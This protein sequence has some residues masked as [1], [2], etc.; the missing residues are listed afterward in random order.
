MI[1]LKESLAHCSETITLIKTHS[2]SYNIKVIGN[3][4]SFWNCTFE[5]L[6]ERSNYTVYFVDVNFHNCL[7]KTTNVTVIFNN[8]TIKNSKVIDSVGVDIRRHIHIRIYHSYIECNESHQGMLLYGNSVVKFVVIS[9]TVRSC[10]LY[11]ENQEIVFSLSNSLLY[12]TFLVIHVL[13]YFKI[14]SVISMV[15][16]TFKNVKDFYCKSSV[17]VRLN[18]AYVTINGCTF[19]A[20]PVSL[21]ISDKSV[22]QTIFIVNISSSEFLN[23][24][25]C[26]D[27]GALWISSPVK[28]SIVTIF[29]CQFKDNKARKAKLFQDPHGGALA[30]ISSDMKVIVANSFFSNNY[31]PGAGNALFV[32]RGINISIQNTSF[33]YEITK[34]TDHLVPLAVVFGNA[35]I[36]NARFYINNSYPEKFMTDL[37]VFELSSVR[38]IDALIICPRWTRYSTDYDKQFPGQTYLT[39][40]V[41]KCLPCFESFYIASSG[42]DRVIY[43]PEEDLISKDDMV[44]SE[45]ITGAR[46]ENKKMWLI[47]KLLKPSTDLNIPMHTNKLQSCEK[48]SFGAY[49]SGNTIYP[50]PNYWGYWHKDKLIFLQ[51][52]PGYCCTGTKKAPCIK[53]NSCAKNKTGILCGQCQKNFSVAILSGRCMPNHIC[54][55]NRWFWILAFLA[56]MAYAIWYTFKYDMLLLPSVIS[57]YVFVP[58]LKLNKAMK[59]IILHY[60]DNC[61]SKSKSRTKVYI[62]KGY[63]GIMVYFVQMKELMKISMELSGNLFPKSIFDTITAY[64]EFAFSIN[65]SKLSFHICPLAGLTKVGQYVYSL[66]FLV[67]VYLSWFIVFAST[68][69]VQQCFKKEKYNISAFKLKL[70]RG[71]VEI[72]KYTYSGFCSIIF[73]SLTCVW[74]RDS[75]VWYYDG[76]VVCPSTWQTGMGIFG[77]VYAIPFPFVLL[78]GMKLLKENKIAPAAFLLSCVCPLPAL[79]VLIV[80]QLVSTVRHVKCARS[81]PPSGTEI[82]SV[83]RG[84]YR[85]SEKDK[86]LYWECIVI[87][88]RLILGGISLVGYT[89]IRMMI[90]VVLSIIF[91]IHHIS[92][93]PF[94]VQSSNHVETLSLNFL[95]LTSIFNLGKGILLEA[96]VVPT[97]KLITFFQSLQF[98]EELMLP[99]LLFFIIL[100][101]IK[102]RMK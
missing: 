96:G 28:G 40:F 61:S 78:L 36:S 34:D 72:M 102:M 47:D 42:R 95:I 7:F 76:S 38:N 91:Q 24:I 45:R 77:L 75:F 93:M 85:L 41:Y 18:N 10:T 37:S 69:I 9:S 98:V 59:S 3:S 35:S 57:Y 79:L 87:F 44:K 17:S 53:Y 99:F 101:E 80:V 14:P 88:R 63:F 51:C 33:M 62:D 8:C 68:V 86:A 11:L 56:T 15:N 83:L 4:F 1:F 20:A 25:H 58:F 81:L 26:S 97:G 13:S 90:T 19:V 54:G 50:L 22:Q 71:I 84:P 82:L 23:A 48:C 12:D 67:A 66:S 52:P 30:L 46:T 64:I 74:V 6:S 100:I 16:T 31:S 70:V 29:Q 94:S 65:F 32:S 39:N 89:S 73:T 92:V 49:C 5:L 60:E 43:N 27:G 21:T 2:Y 55:N